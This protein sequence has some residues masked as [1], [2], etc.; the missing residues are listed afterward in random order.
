MST[1]RGYNVRF[2]YGTDL[3]GDDPPTGGRAAGGKGG[4]FR[5]EADQVWINTPGIGMA[6]LSPPTHLDYI[7][8]CPSGFLDSRS[9]D[10]EASMLY[11]LLNGLCISHHSAFAY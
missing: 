8:T 11:I 6:I 7:Y 5:F 2:R 10:L 3:G 1:V 4:E 9:V